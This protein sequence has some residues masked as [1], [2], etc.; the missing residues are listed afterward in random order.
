MHSFKCYIFNFI[1]LI[2][3]LSVGLTPLTQADGYDRSMWVWEQS[4]RDALYSLSE[5]QELLNF[6]QTKDIKTLYLYSDSYLGIND[7]IERPDYYRSFISEAHSQGIQVHALLGSMYLRTWEYILPERRDDALSM[8][9]NVLGYN[10]N[11]SASERFDGFNVDIEPYLLSDWWGNQPYYSEQYL[12][13]L[14]AQKQLV[15]NSGQNI[16]YGPCIPRWYDEVS[17]L[18]NITW[19]G[20]VKPLYQHLQDMGSYVTIMDYVNDA[21]GIVNNASDELRYADSINR[22]VVIGVETQDVVPSWTTFYGF[23]E[24]EMEAV[25]NA[26]EGSLKNYTSYDGFAI[27][28]YDSYAKMAVIPEPA[29]IILLGLGLIGLFAFRRKRKSISYI[30]KSYFCGILL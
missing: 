24:E 30:D 23:S 12:D 13:T 28:S 21:N 4:T 27:H 22:K 7:V 18:Q 29:N 10:Q 26:A 25:L 1:F 2:I 11:S 8:V 16:E 20:E 3:T 15:I 5:S 19:N 14:S 6:S 17:L 9:R